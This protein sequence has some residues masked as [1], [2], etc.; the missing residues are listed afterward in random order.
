MINTKLGNNIFLLFLASSLFS[1]AAYLHQKTPMPKLNLEMQDKAININQD[2]LRI[3]SFG[4]KRLISSLIWV[5][6]LMQSDEI[7]YKE[8]DRKNWMFLRF[9]S[10]ADLDPLFYQNYLWGGMYLSIIKDDMTAAAD[11]FD[12]GLKHYPDDYELNYRQ[13]F[14]YYFELGEFEKGLSYLSRIENSP[15]MPLSIK[16]IVNKLRF[17]TTL[18]YDLALNYL[19]HNIQNEKDPVLQNKL[20]ND[21]YALKAERDLDCLNNQKDHCDYLD[22]EGKPYLQMNDNWIAPKKFQPYRIY[23]PKK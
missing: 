10:I 23:L 9:K 6:T 21:F 17:E 11:I 15:Q 12:L 19:Y 1:I 8:N 14:N 16:L 22:A 2:A 18:N 3:L 4:N 20:I 13:G 7:Q 5:Q